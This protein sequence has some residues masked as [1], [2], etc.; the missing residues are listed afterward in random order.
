MNNLKD[1]H[2][3]ILG[4]GLSGLA[5]ARWCTRHGARVT[6]ADTREQPPQRDA[7]THECPSANFVAGAFDEDL[8][9]REAWALVARS[10]G[11]APAQLQV[12][13]EWA[14]ARGVPVMGEL[15]LFAQALQSL[16]RRE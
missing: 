5:M 3:L 16:S 8:L 11:L 7:L 6:V 1:Q 15:E 13:R 9:A 4:L 10:P 14:T 12:V 2:V